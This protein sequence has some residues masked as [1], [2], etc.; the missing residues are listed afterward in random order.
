LLF[1]I[2]IFIFLF[3][4]YSS[5]S[6]RTATTSPAAIARLFFEKKFP[7]IYIINFKT[8]TIMEKTMKIQK[9]LAIQDRQYNDQ[10]GQPRVFTSMGMVLTDGIDTLFAEATGDYAR[11]L[12]GH[13]NEGDFVRVQLSMSVR[14]WQDQ[15][16]QTR[17]E[18]KSYISTIKAI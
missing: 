8:K 1:F 6:Q 3:L 4:V 10:Q 9:L 11:S 12:V 17:Y 15:Q 13:L 5:G 18:N 7:L 2:H 14:D 16:G